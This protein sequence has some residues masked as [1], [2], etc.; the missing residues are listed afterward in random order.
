MRFVSTVTVMQ[1]R[2]DESRNT[3][4]AHDEV[5]TAQMKELLEKV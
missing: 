5:F 4:D 3:T 2:M 1:K